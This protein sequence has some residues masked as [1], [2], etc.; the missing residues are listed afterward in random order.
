MNTTMPE[1]D[2][3][4]FIGKER[5]RMSIINRVPDSLRGEV[6]C[7]LC[8]IKQERASHAPGFYEKLLTYENPENEHRI[9]K[10]VDRTFNNYPISGQED[11][12]EIRWDHVLGRKLLFNVLLAYANYDNEIGYVQGMSYIA[13]MMLLY[14]KDEQR[15]FWCLVH[16]LN[17]KNWRL[18]FLDGMPKLMELIGL[19]ESKINNDYPEISQHLEE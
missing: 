12:V 17:R 7:M 1:F 6:W 9:Q 5:L 18:I 13:A 16:L 3:A 8:Q 2:L 14:V 11:D 4:T 15:V 10:D 19:I